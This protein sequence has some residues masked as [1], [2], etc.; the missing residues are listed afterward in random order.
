MGDFEK[1]FPAS[2]C[3]KKKIAC[4]TNVIESLWEKK[5]K[6]YPAHQIARKKNSWWPKI[7]HPSPQELNGRPLRSGSRTASVAQNA[8]V[9]KWQG[10]CATRIIEVLALALMSSHK[11]LDFFLTCFFSFSDAKGRMNMPSVKNTPNTEATLLHCFFR[12]AGKMKQ[13]C[14]GVLIGNLSGY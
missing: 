1:K 9:K 12:R 11:E 7:T 14:T 3:R 2:A 4:S 5:R 6:K 13:P 10:F 8:N